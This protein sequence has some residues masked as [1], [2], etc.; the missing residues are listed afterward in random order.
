MQ[1]NHV[2][3]IINVIAILASPVIALGIT[4]F[5]QDRKEKRQ[6]RMYVFSALM[7]SR[8]LPLS[9]GA[10]RSLNM[11]D[12]YFYNDVKVRTLWKEYFAML[13]NSGLNNEVGHKQWQEKK[14]ELITEMAKVLGY[15]KVISSIDVNRVYYPTGLD[16]SLIRNEAI[17][18]ELLRVLK[19]SSGI[20]TSPREGL[21][22]SNIV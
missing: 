15:G 5:L 2:I 10:I 14:L 17:A 11:I 1:N 9:D 18:E 6:A 7:E 20:Q 13:N 8:H 21:E 3:E 16:K 4:V 12:L 22:E 19:S